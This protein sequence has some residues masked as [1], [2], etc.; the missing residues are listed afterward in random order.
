MTSIAIEVALGERAYPVHV[1]L[2]LVAR[3]RDILPLASHSSLAL[4]T[5]PGPAAHRAAL[6]RGLTGLSVHTLDLPVG[7]EPLKTYDTLA[8][9]HEGLAAAGV[10]RFGA[11]I[12]FGGGALGDVVGFAA[13]TWLRGVAWYV[14]PTTL[15][16]QVD[17][18]IGGKTAIDVPHGKN[19]V[20][21][22][23]QPRG[24]VADSGVLA[25]LPAREIASAFAE[26]VKTALV[27]DSELFA[28]LEDLDLATLPTHAD[29]AYIV[30]RCAAAK[31]RIVAHD[32]REVAGGNGPSRK[33]LNF[34]HTVGHALEAATAYAYYAHGEAVAIGMRAALALSRELG[35]VAPDDAARAGRQVARLRGPPPPPGL[36]LG[37]VRRAL[38]GDKKRAGDA[39]DWV[40]LEGI[41]RPRVVRLRLDDRVVDRVID[42]ALGTA[43]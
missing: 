1:G 4:V 3:L 10:D 5:E 25:T 40:I 28:R 27:A 34:G 17:A 38:V 9:I 24:V 7:G 2:D 22:F 19:L 16:S 33:W 11:V 42:V 35:I 13:A 31:A 15:L 41:G 43:S 23:H 20:G 18:A 26:I 39:I 12:A 29:L 36:D 32:E 30:A 6:T 37:V 21:A 14:V 8:R